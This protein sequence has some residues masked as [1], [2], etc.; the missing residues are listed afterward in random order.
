MSSKLLY[1]PFPYPSERHRRSLALKTVVLCMLVS[2]VWVSISG[3]GKSGNGIYSSCVSCE[4]NHDV[5][6]SQMNNTIKAD[7]IIIASFFQNKARYLREW[8]EFHYLLGVRRF[9]LYDF[10]SDDNPQEILRPYTDIGLVELLQWPPTEY[11]KAKFH[12]GAFGTQFVENMAA[13]LK[14]NDVR[15]RQ[16]GCR[17][18]AF[19]E[20][21]RRSDG[22]ARWLGFLDVNQF[23]Y[24][25]NE[26]KGNQSSTLRTIFQSVE[27]YQVIEVFGDYFSPEGM[28]KPLQR[29][30]T[31]LSPPLVTE[32]FTNRMNSNVGGF[33]HSKVS[34]ANPSTIKGFQ[35][36]DFMWSPQRNA[37]ALPY[38]IFKNNSLLRL[39]HYSY[40]VEDGLSVESRSKN[41]SVENN[42]VPTIEDTSVRFL[43]PQLRDALHKRIST[44]PTHSDDY[45]KVLFD[46]HPIRKAH[47]EKPPHLCIAFLSCKRIGLL[48]ESISR[49]I[50]Y[51]H[52][53]E[54]DID[55]EIALF[56]NDSGPEAVS[57][58]LADFPIDIF[59][60]SRKNVGLSPG[61][62]SLFFGLCRAEYILSLEE[63]WM[64]RY[65]NWDV[66]VP[67]IKM[68]MRILETD[69]TVFEVFLR[70]FRYNDVVHGNRT[71]WFFTPQVSEIAPSEM[72]SS[73]VRPVQYRRMYQNQN[74]I[75]GTYTNGA[76]LKS[77]YRL[78]RVGRQK[79]LNGEPDYADRVAKAGYASAHFC[80]EKNGVC[81]DNWR[82]DVPMM[83]LLFAHGGW[84]RR[85]PGHKEVTGT[86]TK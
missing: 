38:N 53:Y 33:G 25:H 23:V 11:D 34:F 5:P 7:H 70:D 65:E 63:D 8:V 60:I 19:L 76:T 50:R 12:H 18:S 3:F 4:I 9:L 43:I 22:K 84:R 36:P 2:I 37:P 15:R 35:Y 14:D 66:D 31:D 69:E 30:D 86:S 72:T 40:H 62:N 41:N 59:A 20:A 21:V 29:G 78:L 51:M 1:F 79:G 32:V 47:P 6:L 16:L 77:Q 13:C 27:T 83:E 71:G 57:Q 55:Y 52:K 67:A 80:I 28:V 26:D 39:N 64:A 54:P 24:P 73:L 56:D 82:N 75:F 17:H 48:R 49:I 61:L 58:L 45:D 74:N 44:Y 68:A 46:M 81:P 42:F 85:S 10:N